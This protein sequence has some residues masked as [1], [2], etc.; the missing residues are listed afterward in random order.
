MVRI[1]MEIIVD[2]L[3]E[4]F[5]R[6]LKG[7]VDEIAPDNITD[8]RTLMRIFRKKLERGFGH[9]EHVS[10]RSVDTGC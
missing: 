2:E 8:S 3:E 5:S 9:W 4:N 6:V 10:D 7:V 1:N